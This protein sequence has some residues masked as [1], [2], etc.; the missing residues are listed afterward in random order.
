MGDQVL[1]GKK[2]TGMSRAPNPQLYTHEPDPMAQGGAHYSLNTIPGEAFQGA[3][4]ENFA[5]AGSSAE[6]SR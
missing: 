2:H 3:R 1:E 6:K 5:P 4:Q